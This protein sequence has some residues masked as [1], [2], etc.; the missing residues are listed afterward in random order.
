M[1]KHLHL[2]VQV[3]EELERELCNS[4]VEFLKKRLHTV[5]RQTSETIERGL[6]KVHGHDRQLVQACLLN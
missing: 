1:I 2:R 3:L 4:V 5:E 6:A